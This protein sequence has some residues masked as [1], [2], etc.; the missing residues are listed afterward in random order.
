MAAA[1][2]FPLAF[3]ARQFSCC[4]LALD[5]LRGR[6][7]DPGVQEPGETSHFQALTTALSGTVGLGSIAGIVL[8]HSAV[9]T[10][11]PV[12]EGAVALPEPFIDTVTICTMAAQVISIAGLDVGPFPN[13]DGLNA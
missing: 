2:T 13:A 10:N 12:T 1:V 4:K 7:P 3:G 11:E 6:Y 9:K 5:L 8:A